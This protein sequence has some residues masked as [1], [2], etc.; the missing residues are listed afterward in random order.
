MA[1]RRSIVRDTQKGKVYKS[2]QEVFKDIIY[3][4]CMSLDECE[5]FIN[6]LTSSDYYIRFKGF[7]NIKVKSGRGER[8]P[9]YYHY[10]IKTISLPKWARNPVVVIHETIHALVHKTVGDYA[11]HHASFCTHYLNL[12][13]YFMGE[14]SANKL[15]DSFI[16]NKVLFREKDLVF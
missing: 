10:D 5:S 7:K 11:G 2:E 9:A 8:S 12:L 1:Y 13:N 15:K 3:S 14:D 4:E 6:S 16:K